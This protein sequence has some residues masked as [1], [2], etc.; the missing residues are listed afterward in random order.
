MTNPACGARGRGSS[1][2]QPLRSTLVGSA[3]ADSDAEE[4]EEVD[5]REPGLQEAYS[6]LWRVVNLPAVRRLTLLLLT[7]RL[8]VLP[9]E[10]AA[11]LKLL[12]KGVSKEALAG[13]V[14]FKNH[15]YPCT[16][17]GSEG[18]P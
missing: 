13:L 7:F 8:G 4:D 5:E 9:A 1:P 16:G 14:C 12:E 3:E 10:S 6:Q 17:S 15:L 2:C 11:P 18:C